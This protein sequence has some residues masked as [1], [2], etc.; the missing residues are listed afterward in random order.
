VSLFQY[1]GI[2]RCSADLQIGG[3]HD[4]VRQDAD[5]EIGATISPDP[6]HH[7]AGETPALQWI[8]AL[9]SAGVSPAQRPQTIKN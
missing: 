1:S 9:C 6:R 3:D 5:L 4:D 7:Q 2:A 8:S